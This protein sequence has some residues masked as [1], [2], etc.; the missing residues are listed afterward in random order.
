MSSD[1]HQFCILAHSVGFVPLLTLSDLYRVL[2]RKDNGSGLHPN[3]L[4]GMAVTAFRRLHPAVMQGIPDASIVDTCLQLERLLQRPSVAATDQALQHVLNDTKHEEWIMPTIHTCL[5]CSSVLTQQPLAGTGRPLMCY[6]LG[7]P[8][9]RGTAYCKVC[10]TCDLLYDSAGYHR[11]S[12]YGQPGAVHMAYAEQHLPRVW[13]VTSSET[14][15]EQLTLDAYDALQHTAHVAACSFTNAHN[16]LVLHELSRVSGACITLPYAPG[17]TN[18]LIIN[19]HP[20]CCCY[21]SPIV[22]LHMSGIAVSPVLSVVIVS[23]LCNWS[24]CCLWC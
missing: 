6:R 7:R 8:G 22:L 13:Q 5:R 3:T 20:H 21:P 15:L 16:S 1:D 14:A 2:L 17:C 10:L 18:Y 23:V 12:T 19:V 11:R 4:A 24:A 9:A